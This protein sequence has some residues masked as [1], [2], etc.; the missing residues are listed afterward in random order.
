MS[1]R[2]ERERGGGEKKKEEEEEKKKKK[3][4]EKNKKKEE[5]DRERGTKGLSICIK[6]HT[7]M[8]VQHYCNF[9]STLTKMHCKPTHNHK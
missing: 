7:Y 1:L 2:G 8:E 5:R 4:K 6:T 9:E 3:K